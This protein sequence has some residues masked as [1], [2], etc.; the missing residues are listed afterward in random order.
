MKVKRTLFSMGTGVVLLGAAG[1]A[2]ASI[3]FG[4]GFAA[5]TGSTDSN[6]VSTGS[7][8]TTPFSR[9]VTLCHRTHSKKHPGVTITVGAAAVPAHMRHGDTLGACA[10]FAKTHGK[11]GKTTTTSTESTQTTAA[12]DDG[13]DSDSGSHGNGNGHGWGSAG[14]HGASGSHG[15]GKG[16]G[17]G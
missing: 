10:L 3:A 15:N 11:P 7:T 17:R 14:V 16:H 4:G 2:A 1:F 12:N 6:A 8:G 13:T 9:K 5:L